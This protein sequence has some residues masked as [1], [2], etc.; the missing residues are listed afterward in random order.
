MTRWLS[1]LA[2]AAALAVVA[3]PATSRA[4]AMIKEHDCVGKDTALNKIPPSAT[5]PPD[6]GCTPI[7]SVIMPGPTTGPHGN[8][9]GPE[10]ADS[11]PGESFT[12][13]GALEVLPTPSGMWQ[14]IPTIKE[15]NFY[16]AG[17]PATFFWRIG[18]KS[19]SV[20]SNLEVSCSVCA[21]RPQNLGPGETFAFLEGT[22]GDLE[23][24][25][26]II[27]KL[28][29]P[30]SPWG[31]AVRHIC[32]PGNPVCGSRTEDLFVQEIPSLE[33]HRSV[34]KAASSYLE[35]LGCKPKVLVVENPADF[36]RGDLIEVRLDVPGTARESANVDAT[37][38]EVSYLRGCLPGEGAFKDICL[39]EP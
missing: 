16:Q 5:V 17:F 33:I 24:S 10:D 9:Y 8:K 23:G 3:L 37:S 36:F 34:P 6:A 28:N 21:Q 26:P 20:L 27:D 25:A 7:G 13:A 32:S 31:I 15:T 2:V 39:G 22:E 12:E 35:F 38:C 4:G 29:L 19:S 18:I 14:S 1:I 11:F 30:E